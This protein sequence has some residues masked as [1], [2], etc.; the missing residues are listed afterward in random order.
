MAMRLKTLTYG[1]A[2]CFSLVG[3]VLLLCKDN[4]PDPLPVK[5]IYHL[6]LSLW[7]VSPFLVVALAT[8]YG[9]HPLMTYGALVAT[10]LAGLL[11]I[12]HSGELLSLQ[13]SSAF[14]SMFF[15]TIFQHAIVIPILALSFVFRMGMAGDKQKG[16]DSSAPSSDR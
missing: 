7:Y 15:V 6:L 2:A 10:L 9:R 4:F 1:L 12:W 14:M 11:V 13:G 3:P 16:A 5:A 8:R